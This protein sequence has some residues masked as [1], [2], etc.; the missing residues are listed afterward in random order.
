MRDD[1][2]K[3]DNTAAGRAERAQA[4]ARA[5]AALAPFADCKEC[6]GNRMH[7]AWCPNAS[8]AVRYRI[9]SDDDSHEF[10]IPANKREE[11][12]APKPEPAPVVQSA[13]VESGNNFKPEPAPASVGAEEEERHWSPAILSLVDQFRRGLLDAKT[14]DP[15]RPGHATYKETVEA[16]RLIRAAFPEAHFRKLAE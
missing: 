4:K 15:S 13:P 2:P 3:M 12:H 10:I 9:V 5:D 14:I 1:D 6:G 16:W 11:C 7:H 8:K